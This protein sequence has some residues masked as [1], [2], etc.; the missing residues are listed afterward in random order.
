MTMEQ[1]AR[2]EEQGFRRLLAWQRADELASAAYK[3][4]DSIPGRD[5][6]CGRSSAV[7]ETGNAPGLVK[8][9]WRMN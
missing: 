8:N 5:Q 1:G 3:L 7:M 2:S 6:Q 9:T 4:G